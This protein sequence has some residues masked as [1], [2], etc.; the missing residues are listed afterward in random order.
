MS[1]RRSFIRKAGILAGLEFTLKR[2]GTRSL[3][4]SLQ[5]AIGVAKNGF[6]F[7]GAAAGAKAGAKRMGADPGSR[8]LYFR[9][10]KPLEAKDHYSN[11]EASDP[12]SYTLIWDEP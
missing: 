7:G 10:G 1:S 12:T 2:Y 9:D 6:P 5:P 8:A 3:R 4:E 11:Q